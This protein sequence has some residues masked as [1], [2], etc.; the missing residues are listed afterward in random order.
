MNI[1]EKLTKVK[2]SAKRNAGDLVFW[3]ATATGIAGYVWLIVASTKSAERQM[4]GIMEEAFAL[5]TA[6]QG[7]LNE[8]LARGAQVLPNGNDYWIIEADGRVSEI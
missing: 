6:R 5:E 4:V 3:G 8:A 7:T 1:K 2:E